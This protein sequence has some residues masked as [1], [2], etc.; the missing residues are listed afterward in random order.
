M[1]EQA[2]TSTKDRVI[3]ALERNR[4]NF[5]SGE[6][7]AASAGITRSAVW[8]QIET[9]RSEGFSIVSQRNGGHML[10]E[11]CDILSAGGIKAYL[12]GGL[13]DPRRV[14]VYESVDSTNSAAKRAVADGLEGE[15]I[16]VSDQ[17]TEGRGRRGRSFYSP[18]GSGLYF[19]AVL[20][21]DAGLWDATATTTGA[22]VATAEAINAL[23]G[24]TPG[25]KWVNDL[26]SGDKKICGILTEAMTDL[27]S[28]GIQ[29]LIVGIGI[30]LSTCDFPDELKAAAGSLFPDKKVVRDRLAAEIFLRLKDICDR[31]PD[32]SYM[33]RYRELSTVLGKPVRFE[34]K[35]AVRK[36][37]AVEIL[38][39]GA[40]VCDT[41]EGREILRGGEITLRVE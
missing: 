41:D 16:F 25:I 32:R 28:G 27:E 15:A 13:D 19:T 14:F 1:K 18:K 33:T 3:F 4:G 20:R 36:G 34:K 38:D 40:L 12:P 6:S 24:I 29:A 11:D 8:K 2:L 23:T 31:L 5:I 30:N 26:Y 17:Q 35:G 37:K 7:I 10:A 21:T 39:D 9:L 22:A